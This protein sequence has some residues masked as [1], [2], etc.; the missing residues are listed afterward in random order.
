MVGVA[1]QGPLLAFPGDRTEQQRALEARFDAELRADNLRQWMKRLTKRPHH[2]GSPYGKEVAEFLAE[3]FRAWGYDTEI[4]VFH[5]LFPTPLSRRLEM[6]SPHQFVATLEEPTLPE[7]ATSGQKAEQLPTYNVYSIDG[8]VIGE[9][10]YVNYG[11]PDDYR[12][13]ERSVST[14]VERSSSHA[15]EAPGAVSSRKWRPSRA[16]SAASSTRTHKMTG[17]VGEMCIQTAHIG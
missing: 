5:V 6:V 13:L 1:A 12:E 14:S 9:L 8:D 11:T 10:V 15:T 2:V 3:Q 16:R 7:D 17:T 4:E